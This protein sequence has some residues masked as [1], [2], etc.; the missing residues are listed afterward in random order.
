MSVP[1][2][3]TEGAGL[4]HPGTMEHIM[5]ESDEQL[6]EER[7]RVI[8]LTHQTW[9]ETTL[10]VDIVVADE[11]H[12]NADNLGK[13]LASPHQVET[14][15]RARVPSVGGELQI[16]HWAVEILPGRSIRI[17]FT[18]KTG[19]TGTV[20]GVT[21]AIEADGLFTVVRTSLVLSSIDM[22]QGQWMREGPS[23]G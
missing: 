15:M 23:R 21:E 4:T 20:E 1:P 18:Y 17:A 5:D 7:R 3:H 10:L 14:D 19:L 8:R 16:F 2:P 9:S 13:L 12:G 11:T 6:N 22:Q